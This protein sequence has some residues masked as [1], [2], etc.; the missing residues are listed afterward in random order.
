[1]REKRTIIE[2][3]HDFYGGGIEPVKLPLPYLISLAGRQKPR[4]FSISSSY[5]KATN[6]VHMTMAV[7]EYLT[8]FKRKK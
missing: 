5:H 3:M 1:M 7:T 2:V 6:E 8:K 4:E